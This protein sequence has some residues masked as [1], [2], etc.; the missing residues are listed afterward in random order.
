MIKAEELRIGNYVYC[1]ETDSN[2]KVVDI[3]LDD[4]FIEL[5]HYIGVDDGYRY[6]LDQ[7]EPIPLTE[8]W[9]LDFGF[10]LFAWGYVKDGIL[11]KV[12][13]TPTLSFRIEL[14]NGKKIK[15]P[16][17]HTLQN[18]YFCIEQKELIE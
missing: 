9:L 3:Y 2:T 1:S 12:S 5:G 18:T 6:D 13:K 16:F 17:V 7:I 14:V 10:E 11:V 4:D 15:I 8:Q